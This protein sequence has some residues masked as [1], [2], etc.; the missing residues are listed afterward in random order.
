MT[1]GPDIKEAIVEVGTAY[2]IIR[3]SGNVEDNYL[4]FKPNEQVTKPFIREFFLEAQIAHDSPIVAGD[5]IEFDTT[6]DRFIVMHFTPTLFENT[7]IRYESVLYKTNVKVSVLR[8][9]ERRNPQTYLMETYWT[10]IKQDVDVLLTTPLF[11][12][13]LET[14]EELGL[15]GIESHEIWCPSSYGIANLDRIRVT[16][17]V[18]AGNYWRTEAVRKYRFE[19]CEV[20]KVGEDVRPSTT[21]STSS[22]TTTSTSSS[23]STTTTTA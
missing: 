6:G 5:I 3:D 10:I 12:Q 17:G 21:T 15:L 1:I 23:S 20:V 8:P 4:T 18:G 14:A 16:S 19:A 7:V 11:G 22:T 9:G 2:T 13:D